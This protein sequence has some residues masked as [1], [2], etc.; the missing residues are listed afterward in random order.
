MCIMAVPTTPGETILDTCLV[1]VTF[2][3][4]SVFSWKKQDAHACSEKRD[5]IITHFM[6]VGRSS[7]SII[8]RKRAKFLVYNTIITASDL[9]FF[10]TE[11]C[12]SDRTDWICFWRKKIPRT[13]LYVWLWRTKFDTNV[14]NGD[15]T[16]EQWFA[17]RQFVAK[18]VSTLVCTLRTIHLLWSDDY[19]CYLSL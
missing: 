2:R 7:N 1:R 9:Q 5:S 10:N 8:P 17:S 15:F 4:F 19:R 12:H 11:L 3:F 6:K 16:V 18:R 14:R 13:V